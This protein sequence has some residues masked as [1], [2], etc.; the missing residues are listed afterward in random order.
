VEHARSECAIHM[1]I[2]EDTS[3]MLHFSCAT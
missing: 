1:C 2:L 3:K